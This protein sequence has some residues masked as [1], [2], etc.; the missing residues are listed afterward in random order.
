MA[1]ENDVVAA[2][3][4]T[5]LGEA[6]AAGA[7]AKL[8]LDPATTTGDGETVSRAAFAMALNVLLFDDLLRRVPTGAAYVADRIA[9]GGKLLFDHG[10]LRTIRFADGPTGELPAGEAAFTRILEPLGYHM[11]EVYPLPRLKMTGRAYR[12]RDAPETIP[13]FFVSELH[14]DR[15]DAAFGEAAARIFGNSHDPLGQAARTALDLFAAEGAVPFPV[16]AAA[17]PEIVAAFGRHHPA[18]ALAD[19]E[20]LLGQSAEAAWIATEGNAFNHATDRVADV[21]TLAEAQRALGRPMKDQ[22]E[23]SGSGRI[24]QTAFRAD[25]VERKF[26]GLHGE[27]VRRAV[28]G[29]FY[30]FITRKIDPET[31]KLDLGFDSGNAQGIFAMTKTA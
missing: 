19:Y 7:V 4:A 2:L 9:G 14:V 20:T 22:V 11:A 25:P 12:H 21:D 8:D 31:G 18:P 3:V 27:I 26:V 29:S 13:Q 5:M 30:E 23:I 16:A 24:R 10:A 28:P 17:L 6:G 15:F 1:N